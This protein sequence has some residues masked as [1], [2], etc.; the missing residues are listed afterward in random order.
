ME[1]SGFDQTFS[2]VTTEGAGRFQADRGKAS[3]LTGRY[4]YTYIYTHIPWNHKEHS[5]IPSNREG[6]RVEEK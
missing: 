3:Y 4:I 6:S 5:L 1:G 2:K